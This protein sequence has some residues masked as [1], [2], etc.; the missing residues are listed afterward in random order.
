MIKNN[1][2]AL[3]LAPI[4]LFGAVIAAQAQASPP[5]AARSASSQAELQDPAMVKHD[6]PPALAAKAKISLEAARKT[7]MAAVPGG[8]V[9]SEEL[10]QEH[11]RLIYSFDIVLPGKPGVEEVNVSARSGKIVAKHHETPRAEIKEQAKEQAPQ[12]P[13]PR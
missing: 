4:C 10:E 2:L 1:K 13:P 7:A 6:V 5:S 11:G 12:K 3:L 8:T 9:R